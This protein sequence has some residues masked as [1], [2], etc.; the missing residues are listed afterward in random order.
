MENIM[1]ATK[2]LIGADLVPT[3]HTAEKFASGDV[4]LREATGDGEKW[5]KSN[6]TVNVDKLLEYYGDAPRY[7]G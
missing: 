4:Y 1:K 7:E 6:E 5:Y 3:R 2:I